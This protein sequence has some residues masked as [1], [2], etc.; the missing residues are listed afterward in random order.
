MFNAVGIAVALLLVVLSGCAPTLKPYVSANLTGGEGEKMAILPFD[1][2]SATQGASKVME[3]LVL[4][5]FLRSSAVKVVDPGE[6]S[7]ALSKER[8]RLAS[9]ISKESIRALGAGLGVRFL[10]MGI[11]HQFEVQGSVG[12]AGGQ[13][14]AVGLAL[15]IVDAGT[16]E[17][18]WAGTAARRGND[19]EIVF[20]I[21]KIHSLNALGE[22][23]A[24]EFARAFAEALGQEK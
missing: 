22:E 5:E 15:R 24:A 3:N 6:V 19:R 20:G 4:I 14:P 2:L 21:G 16:G 1:N 11:V 17:I 9:N 23:T 12:G 13:T 7:A 8:I 18:V 10:M